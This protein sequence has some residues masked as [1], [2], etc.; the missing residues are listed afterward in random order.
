MIAVKPR[1]L[2]INAIP[3]PYREI[4]QREL[5]ALKSSERALAV[6]LIGSVAR[7][8]T[9]IG[10]DLD[11]EVIIKGDQPTRVVLTEQEISVDYVYISEAR[12]RDLYP[13]TVPI[14]DPKGIMRK[15]LERLDEKR[16]LDEVK[17]RV[18][19]YIELSATNLEKANSVLEVEPYSALCFTHLGGMYLGLCTVLA[20]TRLSPGRRPVSKLE[21]VMDEIK[22]PDLFKVYLS[23]YG[24]PYT[25]KK[26]ELLLREVE[27]GLREI[28][29]YFRDKKT[30]PPYIIQQPESESYL[31]NRIRPIYEHDKRDLVRIVYTIFPYILLEFFKDIGEEDLPT[32]VFYEARKFTGPAASWSKRYQKALEFIPKTHISSLVDSAHKLHQEIEALPFQTDSPDISRLGL[33]KRC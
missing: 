25:L 31:E 9:W 24:M 11:I 32:R 15:A 17:E 3:S 19:C 7:R 14:Y 16:I 1:N 18:Q 6:G 27:E 22:R 33:S 28:W 20:V 4:L 26:A 13:D 29:G 12:T 8:D 21:K 2:D 10:S 5:E 23:L 30:G